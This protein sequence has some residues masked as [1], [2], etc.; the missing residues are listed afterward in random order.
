MIET[1]GSTQYGLHVV[2]KIPS[3]TRYGLYVTKTPGIT[4]C[5]SSYAIPLLQLQHLRQ[6]GMQIPMSS[7]LLNEFWVDLYMRQPMYHVD[8][9]HRIVM[10]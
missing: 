2:A 9:C 10:V 8:F 5:G 1:S 4:Q 7:V 6:H 3:S